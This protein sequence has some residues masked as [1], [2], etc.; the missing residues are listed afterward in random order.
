[1]THVMYIL[2]LCNCFLNLAMLGAIEYHSQNTSDTLGNIEFFK[3][4]L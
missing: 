4:L 3:R 2:L 1:M